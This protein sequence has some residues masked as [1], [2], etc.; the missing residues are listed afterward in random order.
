MTT[1]SDFTPL[2]QSE[3]GWK[4]AYCATAAKAIGR[5]RC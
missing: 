5:S 2:V 3:F 4:A 1:V